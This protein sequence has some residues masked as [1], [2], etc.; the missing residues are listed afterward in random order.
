MTIFL[1]G[2]ATFQCRPAQFFSICYNSIVQRF[3]G[4]IF[5][6]LVFLTNFLFIQFLQPSATASFIQSPRFGWF[7]LIVVPVYCLGAYFKRAPLQSR[8]AEQKRQI[9]IGAGLGCL[10]F[11]QWVLMNFLFFVN[12]SNFLGG[13]STTK[14]PLLIFSF[15]FLPLI[16][17]GFTSQA[18]RPYDTKPD[19]PSWRTHQFTEIFAD[20]CL[21][22][23]VMASMPVWSLYA[24]SIMGHSE[25]NIVVGVLFLFLATV[26]F[27][28]FYLAP[29]LLLLAE[30]YRQPRTWVQIFI[31]MSPL[32]W[33]V[34]FG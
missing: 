16:L 3:Q 19:L 1:L 31:A 22:I 6:S 33:R 12:I 29:R 14:H 28:L 23:F 25:G 18:L 8:L 2:G 4:L 32:A 11:L 9:T 27:A 7:A 34:V 17:V 21:I 20:L 30:D 13:E 10:L 15:I 24:G 5:D 26:P